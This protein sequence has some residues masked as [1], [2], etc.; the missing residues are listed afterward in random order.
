[1]PN[2]D[3]LDQR[4]RRPLPRIDIDLG[5]LSVDP[6]RTRHLAQT[7][8]RPLRLL[9][10]LGDPRTGRALDIPKVE[11]TGTPFR[12]QN[13]RRGGGRGGRGEGGHR[14]PVIRPPYPP[15][16]I[17]PHIERAW[18]PEHGMPIG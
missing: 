3:L 6:E 4:P 15:A 13:Q 18:N 8:T 9:Q 5:E 17:E 7:D 2:L 10:Q 12:E 1:M 11:T 16:Q 14:N